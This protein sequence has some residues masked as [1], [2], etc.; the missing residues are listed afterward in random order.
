MSFSQ[1]DSPITQ[2]FFPKV[3]VVVPIYNGET[4]LPDLISCIG[5][6]T[7]PADRVDYLLVDNASRD[8][9]SHL[10]Q[11]AAVAASSQG[12]TIRYL[13]ENQIQSSYAARNTGI[14]A[15]TGEI[16]AFTD[17]DC[18]PMPDWLATLIQPFV[19]PAVGIV[20]GE[21]MALP[22][23][24]LLEKHAEQQDTLSQKYTIAH[25]FCPYGQTANLAIRR[26]A[27]EQVGLFRPYLTT[28]GDADICWRIQ[29][30]SNWQLHFA[31]TAIVRHRHRSTLK[32]LQS[33]WRRYGCSNRYLHE[34]HGIQ[35]TRELTR[36]E[37]LYRLSRWLLKELPVTSVK[38]I[39][40][41][42]SLTHLLSTPI[43]LLNIQAR[44]AG[45]R[46]A[47]LPEQART[48]EWLEIP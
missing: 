38:A 7:Y 35:L 14:R 3:S 25:S 13:T 2:A 5:A 33:Q 10:I 48:I 42:A 37:Y 34:L 23:T 45:Q 24:T 12:L 22:G 8:R 43:D 46:E 29:Q 28:G 30:Q 26:Q 11:E 44:S 41:K 27:F 19:N 16:I 9:T 17:A 21:I 40:G 6:Q 15:S 36:Q 39:A 32:E 1:T 4:D 18:R 31:S 47:K 20:A